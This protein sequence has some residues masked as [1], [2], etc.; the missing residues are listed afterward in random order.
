MHTSIPEHAD[1]DFHT[2]EETQTWAAMT[3][4]YAMLDGE[5]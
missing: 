2:K 5:D 3:H 1:P 4:P